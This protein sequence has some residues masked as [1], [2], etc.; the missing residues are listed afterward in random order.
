MVPGQPDCEVQTFE[1]DRQSIQFQVPTGDA[2][3]ASVLV[4]ELTSLSSPG[5][6]GLPVQAH[7]TDLEATAAAPATLSLRYDE[8]LL[9]GRGWA[10]VDVFRRADGST[11]YV[12]LQ[13]CLADGSP[14]N[15]EEACVD[16]RGLPVS[17]RDVVE[18]EG[19]G[20]APDVIMVVRTVG[21]S[22]W[23]AR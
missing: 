4:Q 20:A 15:G 5:D 16:R 19:P 6:I 17:S 10:T 7:A 3:G 18:A 11:T 13:S 2:T 9:D 14:P 8:R 23:V 1:A 12:R 22:R 21:T